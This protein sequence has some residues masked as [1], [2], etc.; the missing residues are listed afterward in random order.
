MAVQKT[1]CSLFRGLPWSKPRTQ[2]MLVGVL[3][4][5]AMGLSSWAMAKST[6]QAPTSLIQSEGA[7]TMHVEVKRAQ[8]D[9]LNEV[10]YSQVFSTRQVRNLQMS[11]LVPRT[12]ALK[13]A[14]VYFPGGGFKSADFTK[15]IE[16]RY[17]LANAGFVVAA[18]QYRTVPDVF[19]APLEDAKSAVRYLRAHAKELGIDP[20]RIGVVGDSAGGWLVDLVGTTN[21]QKQYDKGQNLDQSSDVQAVVSL[22]GITNVLNI[23]EGFPADIQKVHASPAVTEAL[24]VNG[25]AFNTFAGAPITADPKKALQASAMGHLDGPKPP[26]LLMHG[27]KDTLVS[28][29]QSKQLYE[30]LKARGQRVQYVIVDNGEHGNIVW[31]Q[32]PVTDFIVQWF[33]KTLGAPI[34]ETKRSAQPANDNL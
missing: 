2:M 13:P 15:Y 1:F 5:V 27:A 8:I 20:K 31:F 23:G 4:S 6:Y 3:T 24:Y 32:Q 17:A 18:A 21:G 29:I 33:Q 30:A 19:P 14:I 10:T 34:Q 26:F 25:V 22:Y 11:I 9:Q 28:P 12:Q 16:L 7:Q